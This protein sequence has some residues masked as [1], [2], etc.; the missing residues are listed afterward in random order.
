[1]VRERQAGFAAPQHVAEGLAQVPGHEA[2]DG[3]FTAGEPLVVPDN[4][5]QQL[6][7]GAHAGSGEGAQLVLRLARAGVLEVKDRLELAA[8]PDLV[9]TVQVAVHEHLR[10]RLSQDLIGPVAPAHHFPLLLRRHPPA[11]PLP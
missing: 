7:P 5:G 3:Q 6:K 2:P 10:A 1:V 9:V 4:R 11:E 8:G